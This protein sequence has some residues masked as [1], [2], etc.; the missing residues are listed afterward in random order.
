MTETERGIRRAT[1]GALTLDVRSD[2]AAGYAAQRKQ[3]QLRNRNTHFNW[4]VVRMVEQVNN[5]PGLNRRK[6]QLNT[7][8]DD[9]APK[10]FAGAA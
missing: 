9:G 10:R 8:S 5:S 1:R 2:A 4:N 3:A 7:L 6:S